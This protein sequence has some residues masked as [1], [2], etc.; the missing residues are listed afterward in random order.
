MSTATEPRVSRRVSKKFIGPNHVQLVN[1]GKDYFDLLLRLISQ[2]TET[3]HLQTYIFDADET[4]RMV[5]DA[6]MRAAKR[7][8]GVYVLVDGYA[9]RG[10]PKEFVQEI[11]DAGVF[12]RFFEP[13]LKAS[14]Y[15]FGR[16]MHHKIFVA[17][18]IHSLTGGI[19]IS[20]RYNDINNEPAWLDFGLYTYG[21]V[22]REFCL[23]CNNMW[24]GFET[25]VKVPRCP[26]FKNVNGVTA[27]GDA[28][29]R[30]RRNDWVRGR[31]QISGSY[32]RMLQS[33]KSHIT[34]ISSYFLPGER[35]KRSLRRAARR[36]VKIQVV[37][38]GS[39][40][41][42]I[43]KNA[44]RYVYDWLLRH[45]IEIYE[46]K[47]RVLHAKVACCDGNWMTIGSYNINDISAHASVEANVEVSD[48]EF[49]KKVEQVFQDVIK[50]DCQLI[51]PGRHAR[52][53]NIIRQ[54]LRWSAYITFRFL[55]FV[56]TFYFKR[57]RED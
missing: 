53:K 9:S 40:D 27:T 52:T 13:L 14:N 30:I 47:E 8:V 1:G 37:V 18:A 42:I 17:D 34:I 22:A 31:N 15:Y 48:P 23:V 16:R 38:A 35:F 2:A 54:F 21:K 28:L 39:S 5:A 29:V 10:L 51:T 25:S 45:N 12:F 7:G 56:F 4:G 36:G 55:L 33:S 11:R 44:E 46:V 50:N 20:D 32:L 19:N 24:R 49:V 3:I 41:V 6:L 57:K 26:Q 43:A